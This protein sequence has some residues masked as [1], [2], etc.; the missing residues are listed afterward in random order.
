MTCD[1]C[2]AEVQP[3]VLICGCGRLAYGKRIAT[4]AARAEGYEEAGATGLARSA[5]QEALGFLP[6]E[7][8]QAKTIR[9]R[10]DGL[11]KNVAAPAFSQAPTAALATGAPAAPTPQTDTAA[12]RKGIAG[13]L[14]GLAFAFAKFG[15]LILTFIF[16]L[17]WLLKATKFIPSILSMGLYVWIYTLYFGWPFAVGFALLIWIHE[18]GHVA[19]LVAFGKGFELPIFIP[20]AGAYVRYKQVGGG[21]GSK[22]AVSDVIEQAWIALGGPL[23]GS[24]GAFAAFGAGEAL[25]SDL[26][27][28]LGQIGLWINLVN[29]IPIWV[30]DGAKA[31][32]ALDIPL[33]ILV[34]ALVTGAAFVAGSPWLGLVCLLAIPVVWQNRHPLPGT[35]LDVSWGRRLAPALVLGA[36][37]SGLL[38]TDSA[39]A[40]ARQRVLAR[41]GRSGDIA[42]I[43]SSLD[44]TTPEPEDR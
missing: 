15:K 34:S 26:L 41:T 5:W 3:R 28:M 39:L 25:D 35:F 43:D 4:L 18:M 2:G 36:L 24:V 33:W 8:G 1:F 6:P 44:S 37:A 31:A 32:G 42:A 30:L 12:K 40:T 38:L 16:K 29:L 21:P 9:E 10:V 22:Y 17:K 7:S 13:V 14:G 27:R 11:E 23:L 19:M 20:F